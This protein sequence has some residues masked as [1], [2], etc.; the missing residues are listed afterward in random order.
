METYEGFTKKQY[1]EFTQHVSD[2]TYLQ[3]VI[4]KE[5]IVAREP[6]LVGEQFFA[7]DTSLVGTSGETK[8]F[9]TRNAVYAMP[10][11]EGEDVP[12]VADSSGTP[13]DPTFTYGTAKITPA[14]FGA[15]DTITGLDIETA[16]LNLIGQT[17]DAIAAAMARLSDKRAWEIM[18]YD[19]VTTKA[20]VLPKLTTDTIN[21]VDGTTKYQLSKTQVTNIVSVEINSVAQTMGVD[22]WIDFYNGR[23]E[24]AANPGTHAA[25][26]VVV[27]QYTARNATNATTITTLSY[28]DLVRAKTALIALQYSPKDAIANDVQIGDLEVDDKYIAAAV[29]SKGDQIIRNG[30]SGSVTGLNTYTTQVL[31]NGVTVVLERGNQMGYILWKQNLKAKTEE[32]AN[33]AGDIKL[34]AWEVSMPGVVGANAIHVI[35]NSHPLAKAISI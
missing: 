28:N 24:L 20:G 5:I 32:I 15:S 35:L 13:I 10:F 17:K 9:R 16:D 25:W 34:K 26:L 33:K 30:F 18:L 2:L 4:A 23:I 27:F 31:P 1:E 8:T 22:Y 29:S 3:E 7:K 6:L 21:T 12:A 19:A 14:P 11:D